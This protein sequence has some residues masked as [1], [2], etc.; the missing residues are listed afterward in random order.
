MIPYFIFRDHVNYGLFT[1]IGVT[2]VILIAFGYVKALV[3]GCRHK[4]AVW[5]AVQTLLVGA[6]AAGVSYGIVRGVNSVQKA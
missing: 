4:D 2:A 1:S 3:T 6:V 5:S